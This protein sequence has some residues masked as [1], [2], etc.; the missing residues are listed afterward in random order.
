MHPLDK[1]NQNHNNNSERDILQWIF[2]SEGASFE[3]DS[4]S[5]EVYS[6]KD[7]ELVTQ[8][9]TNNIVWSC[10]SSIF[11]YNKSLHK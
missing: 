3:N 11:N 4:D 7:L 1:T 2:D 10:Y 9:N 5:E 8:I 6:R